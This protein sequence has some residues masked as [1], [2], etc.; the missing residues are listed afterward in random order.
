MIKGDTP[1]HAIRFTIGTG[2][3]DLRHNSSAIGRIVHVSGHMDTASLNN[4]AS[5]KNGTTHAADL[6]LPANVLARDIAQIGVHFISGTDG[7][8]DTTDNWNMES[9]RIEIVNADGS[10][11]LVHEEAGNPIMRFSGQITDW[12]WDWPAFTDPRVVREVVARQVPNPRRVG[13][14][15]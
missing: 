1:V 12:N 10:T 9:I 15:R 14:P 4:K 8:F 7:P 11:L 5:W 6:E 3:D 2:D 13:V